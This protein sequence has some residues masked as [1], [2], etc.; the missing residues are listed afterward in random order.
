MIKRAV[1]ES[2]TFSDQDAD[3]DGIVDNPA[4]LNDV[5]FFVARPASEGASR[6]LKYSW[7]VDDGNGAQPAEE[8]E[9]A[10]LEVPFTTSGVYT[11]AVSISN[12][13]DN[14]TVTTQM[15]IPVVNQAFPVYVSTDAD[16]LQFGDSD[17][18]KFT[19]SIENKDTER[20]I[21][22]LFSFFTNTLQL[23]DGSVM[24]NGVEATLANGLPVMSDTLVS[25]PDHT[26][27]S[28][29]QIP[30]GAGEDVKLTF[31]ATVTAGHNL[32]LGDEVYNVSY[33]VIDF[34]T[35]F[36]RYDWVTSS[37][38]PGF[39][40]TI[41]DGAEYTDNSVVNVG[42]TYA[43]SVITAT[44]PVTAYISNDPSFTT[45]QT[46]TN[47]PATGGSFNDWTLSDYGST[48]VARNVYIYFED[49]NA[50]VFGPYVDDITLDKEPPA[51]PCVVGTCSGALRITRTAGASFNFFTDD[52]NS[53]VSSL[54]LLLNSAIPTTTTVTT[55]DLQD[56]GATEVTVA[57]QEQDA[58]ITGGGDLTV[59]AVDRSG[60]VSAPSDV[61]AVDYAIYLPIVLK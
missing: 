49:V 9:G 26:T 8:S 51:K 56:A 11:V 40:V 60:N 21:I 12:C 31:E 32:Q 43:T 15:S 54:L 27:L 46:Q 5:G 34:D 58:T 3:K 57:T 20:H 4:Y 35:T 30:M 59:Y 17:T 36:N 19:V 25:I 53:G 42:F 13:N 33:A 14:A 38:D 2:E 10:H 41:N 24:Y 45:V 16:P 39:S 1:I 37:Y 18:I 52:D 44:G 7:T 23:V 47:A 61:I 55:Q 22:S 6:P 28:W 50:D 48:K 29:L